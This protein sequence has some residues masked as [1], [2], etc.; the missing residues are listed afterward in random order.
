[1]VTQFP[2]KFP[3]TAI[4]PTFFWKIL[5]SRN[6]Y[7]CQ[8]FKAKT[9]TLKK[10]FAC[11]RQNR[12]EHSQIFFARGPRW[13]RPEKNPTTGG[14]LKVLKHAHVKA[15]LQF[16]D[17]CFFF[18]REIFSKN[19]AACGGPKSLGR[20]GKTF[21]PPPLSP[22][23]KCAHLAAFWGK[24]IKNEKTKKNIQQHNPL[25]PPFFRRVTS[26]R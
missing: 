10:F 19:F 15:N 9:N 23:K 4:V 18:F 11:G 24:K 1:M 20:T 6:V 5:N 21:L 26:G 8:L 22:V 17:M 13:A 7:N 16:Q 3:S 14:H 25:P 12:K 2:R